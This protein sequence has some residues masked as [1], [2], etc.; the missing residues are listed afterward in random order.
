MAKR[1]NHYRGRSGGRGGRG[2]RRHHGSSRGRGG[3]R[4]FKGKGRHQSSWLKKVSDL[5]N[6]DLGNP[7]MDDVY[8]GDHID[9]SAVEEYY[10]GRH[11]DKSMSMGGF[12]PGQR[13]EKPGSKVAFRKRPMTFVKAEDVYDPSHDIIEALRKENSHLVTPNDPEEADSGDENEE[14]EEAEEL[15][16]EGEVESEEEEKEE[17]EEEEKEKEEEVK[18]EEQ[19]EDMD[20]QEAPDFTT[21]RD[22]DLYLMDDEGEE[23]GVEVKSV[24]VEENNNTANNTEYDPTITVG[25]VQLS[26]R[27]DE[28]EEPVGNRRTGSP[29]LSGTMGDLKICESATP[30]SKQS[31]DSESTQDAQGSQAPQELPFGMA[32]EDSLVDLSEI[33]ITNVRVGFA[34]DSYYV[35][36]YRMFGDHEPKWVGRDNLSDFILEELNFPEHRLGAYLHF[37]KE[38]IIKPDE[39]EP[40]Y[41]DI[42]LSDS[43]SEEY[44]NEGFFRDDE[45]VSSD[46]KEGLD[47]LIAYTE[48]YNVGRN[49]EYE[50]STLNSVGKGKKRRLLIDESL[51]LD[52]ATIS[53]LE[54]KFRTRTETKANKR[55]TKQDFIDEMNQFSEDLFKKYPIGLHIQNIKDE[56]ELFLTKNRDRLS[57]PPLDPH[58]NNVIL[59]MSH[60]FNLKG[61][62][63]GAGKGTHVIAQKTRGT[64]RHSPDYN[65]VHQLLRQRPVFYRIDVNRPGKTTTERVK[66]KAKFHTKE[67]E[68]VGQDAPVIGSDNIGRR[69]LE[70]LGW[71]NG[72][73]LGARG[74]KGIAEPLMAKVKKS[75]SGLKQSQ[76]Q[77]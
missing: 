16:A 59:K 74:N 57:F 76:D 48:K 26:V 50:T 34:D 45:S 36:C 14:E 53:T 43:D 24:H 35:K 54:D 7:D 65:R 31:Q 77:Q 63:E 68:V 60:H 9:P 18:K 20:K 33:S 8:F 28:P 37:I 27:Q 1:H 25:K 46:M 13:E 52:S 73:G 17:E 62:R 40:T 39:P 12:R 3:G 69:M 58:G 4:F 11:K 29:Q 2:G 72:E 32:E 44:E 15:E 56:C 49:M 75:K 61:Y 10:F 22:E 66:S 71:S 19:D 70:K 5:G 21:V 38:S 47:D 30:P 51:G 42:P 41:S 64:E 6:G 23:S 67:G 55:R